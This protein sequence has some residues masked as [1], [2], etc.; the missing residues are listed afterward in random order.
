MA[1][2]SGIHQIRGKVGEMSYYQQAGVNAGLVRRINQGLSDRV[3]TAAE[4]AN[5]RLNNAEFK[6]ASL[7]GAAAG[8]SVIPA[9]RSMFRRFAQANMVKRVQEL[10]KQDTTHPW[11]LRQPIGNMGRVAAELLENYAKAG[12]YQGQYGLAEFT[13]AYDQEGQIINIGFTLFGSE[14]TAANLIAQGITGINVYTVGGAMF[15]TIQDDAVRVAAGHSS[16]TLSSTVISIGN[17]FEI[18]PPTVKANPSDLGLSP[19]GF[20]ELLESDN[21]G[22]WEVVSIVPTRNVGNTTYE[23]QELATYVV[24]GFALLETD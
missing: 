13:P 2:Q 5:T 10:I 15:T 19:R 12:Q 11:G 24:A 23:L 7:V 22:I 20:Q 9:W 21:G 6:T 18:T 3:K 17:D 16:S 1:K 14:E 4:F 8:H